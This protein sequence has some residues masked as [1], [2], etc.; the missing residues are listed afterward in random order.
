[1]EWRDEAV[2][3]GVRQHGETASIVELLTKS[4]GRHAGVVRGGASRKWRGVLQPGN[5][6]LVEWRARLE[7]HLGH[8]TIDLQQSRAAI[9]ADRA[10]LRGLNAMTAMAHFAL[11]ERYPLPD[12]YTL[13]Q[14]YLV[15]LESGPDWLSAFALWEM[16]LLEISGYGLDLSTCAVT[17]QRDDLIYISPKSGRAVSRQGAG[18]WAQR[19]LP[20]PAFMR[21]GHLSHDLAEVRQALALNTYFFEHRVLPAIDKSK[22]PMARKLLSDHLETRGA[23]SR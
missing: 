12:F 20:L 16:N 2:I 18:E 5:N 6:L 10:R 4:H 15:E 17:G 13:T 21:K 22:L 3:L 1:M 14:D 19:M 7:T 23:S 9:M 11:P 8:Y